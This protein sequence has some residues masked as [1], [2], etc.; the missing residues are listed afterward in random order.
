MS[1]TQEH[2]LKAAVELFSEKGFAN[3]TTRDICKH[4]DANV[5][6]VNYHFKGKSGLGDAVV[7]LLFENVKFFDIFQKI[8]I[9]WYFSKNSNFLVFF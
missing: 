9:F 2:I 3:T 4:A 5:A 1:S 6:A 8:R 7:D